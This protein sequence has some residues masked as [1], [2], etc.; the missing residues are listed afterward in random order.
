MLAMEADH[1]QIAEPLDLGSVGL[2]SEE[3]GNN[4]YVQAQLSGFVQHTER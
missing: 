1:W 2:A 4:L 3:V